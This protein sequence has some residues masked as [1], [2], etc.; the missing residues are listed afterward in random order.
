MKKASVSRIRKDMTHLVE[1]V[2][3]RLA[4]SAGDRAAMEYI[5][6]QFALAADECSIEEFPVICR[7]VK[8][9][10]LEIRIGGKWQKFPASLFGSAPEVGS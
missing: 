1:K 2:G 5:A 8:S 6:D 10:V 7:D 3:L 4:G 9:E